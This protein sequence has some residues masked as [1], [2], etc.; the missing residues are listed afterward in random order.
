MI[1][2]F[3]AGILAL[4]LIGLIF[5]IIRMRRL[6]KVGLGDGGIPVLAQAMRMHGNFVETVPFTLILMAIM[7]Y[8]LTPGWIVHIYGVLLLLARACHAQGILSTPLASTGRTVGVILTLL[9]LLSGSITII[10]QFVI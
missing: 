9:L 6:Y 10:T 4:G 2:G 5:N 7:E 8:N 3:Y 1:T